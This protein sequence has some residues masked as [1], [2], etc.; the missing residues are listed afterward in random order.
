MVKGK[1]TWNPVCQFCSESESIHHL[2]FQ[3][4]AAK[5]ICAQTVLAKFI[6]SSHRNI[7]IVGL[8]AI[9]LVIWIISLFSHGF[10]HQFD[11]CCL[12]GTFARAVVPS[13]ASTGELFCYYHHS[14]LF[15]L[16]FLLWFPEFL[17][18]EGTNSYLDHY[19]RNVIVLFLFY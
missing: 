5:K 9:C 16:K 18:S 11:V 15:N 19:L 6:G 13:D 7:Q 4:S 10:V 2:F 1:W 12:D 17:T 8:V 3:C 14:L